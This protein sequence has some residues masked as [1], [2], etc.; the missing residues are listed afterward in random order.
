MPLYNIEHSYP[1]K[2]QEKQDL[3]DRITKLHGAAFNTLSMFVQV[4]FFQQDASA[5]NHYVGG[6]PQS[7]ASNRIIS[8]VRTGSGRK[9]EDFDKLAKQ[10]ED[11]WY[12]VL[13]LKYEDEEDEEKA[14]KNKDKGPS[15]VEKN[16][17][18]LLSIV[19]IGGV[20]GREKGFPIPVVCLTS[21]VQYLVVQ[22]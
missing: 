19:F 15:E 20:N 3:A 5:S 18:E 6:I 21:G 7:N 10:I 12:I 2:L 1:L 9:Q 16:A 11:A 4:K 17:K 13:G 22:C 14:K 8:L